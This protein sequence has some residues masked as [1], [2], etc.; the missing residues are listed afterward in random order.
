MGKY[1]HSLLPISLWRASSVCVC[2]CEC[3][4]ACTCM[5]HACVCLP[6]WGQS[7]YTPETPRVS[8]TWSSLL[9]DRI[10]PLR[11]QTWLFLI[12][13]WLYRFCSGENLFGPSL[14]H[15]SPW[16]EWYLGGLKSVKRALFSVHTC[17]FFIFWTDI[18]PGGWRQSSKINSQV[19]LKCSLKVLKV[20]PT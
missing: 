14:T 17:P 13:H 8:A 12:G 7:R 19:A 6:V 20:L 1:H 18:S 4:W 11:E 2:V 3:V 15:L 16:C 10:K 9:S 5:V